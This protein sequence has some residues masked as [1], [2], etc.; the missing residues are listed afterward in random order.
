MFASRWYTFTLVVDQKIYTE[1]LEEPLNNEL[2]ID[3]ILY[4]TVYNLKQLFFYTL[5]NYLAQIK[6]LYE[7]VLW[8]LDNG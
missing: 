1:H 5:T 7:L 2:I 4:D 3:T 8:M 6:Y